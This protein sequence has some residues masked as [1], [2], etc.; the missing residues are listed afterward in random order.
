MKRFH[1]AIELPLLFVTAAALG[2]ATTT[3]KSA[4]T[5]PAEAKSPALAASLLL[6]K[7]DWSK[8]TG[9]KEIET[10]LRAALK[11]A[12][13]PQDLLDALPA[14]GADILFA[15]EVAAIYTPPHFRE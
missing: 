4:V 3:G 15:P 8:S 10:E 9:A 11:D 2:Q 12:T 14:S 7:A 1:F 13:V 5:S 6:I